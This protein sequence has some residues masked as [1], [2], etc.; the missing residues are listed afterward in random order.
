[1]RNML[2]QRFDLMQSGEHTLIRIPRAASAKDALLLVQATAER[3]GDACADLYFKALNITGTWANTYQKGGYAYVATSP[4][5]SLGWRKFGKVV[6]KVKWGHTLSG[7]AYLNF[8][9]KDLDHVGYDV[10]GV[11]GLDDFSEAAKPV[12]SCA[13]VMRLAQQEESGVMR[14]AQQEEW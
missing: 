4:H 11:L 1:M 2:G 5:P 12:P 3:E 9:V 8:F 10:G 6:L 7:I 13:G 14:L